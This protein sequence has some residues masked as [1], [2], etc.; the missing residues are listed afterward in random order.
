MVEVKVV[1]RY[2]G[3]GAD[4]MSGARGSSVVCEGEEQ[5]NVPV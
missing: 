3:D 5:G 2:G 1:A 4:T